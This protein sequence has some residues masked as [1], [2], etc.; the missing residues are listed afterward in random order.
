MDR[1]LACHSMNAGAENFDSTVATALV[2]AHGPRFAIEF[3]VACESC[4]GA[5]GK[6]LARH[7]ERSWKSLSDHQKSELGF[8]DRLTRVPTRASF[9]MLDRR[10]PPSI[11]I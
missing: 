10:E 3:G 6:W 1:C 5:A 8:R 4:H 2:E 9:V 11:T 7:T